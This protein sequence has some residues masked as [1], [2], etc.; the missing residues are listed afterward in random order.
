MSLRDKGTWYR[1]FVAGGT[2]FR[3]GDFAS[4]VFRP[5]DV[6]HDHVRCVQQKKMWDVLSRYNREGETRTILP[7]T[8]LG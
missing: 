2:R 4:T 7:S 1:N 8:G 6:G 3:Q 5:E